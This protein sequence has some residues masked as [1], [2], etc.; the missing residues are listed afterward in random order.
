MTDTVQLY[1]DRRAAL[2]AEVV[3]TRRKDVQVIPLGEKADVGI[4]FIVQITTPISGHPGNPSF[5]VRFHGTSKPLNDERAANRLA[6]QVAETPAR[7][8][9]L[10]PIVLMVFSMEDDRGYWGWLME[11]VGIGSS[12]PSLQ[13]VLRMEMREI[14]NESLE[15]LFSQVISWFEAA[16]KFL[17][18]QKGDK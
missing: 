3:L 12:G 2:L 15:D 11:P 7:T 16:S 5:G 1:T 14:N 18:R 13:S 8:P 17:L 9:L 4:D 6:N 10:A